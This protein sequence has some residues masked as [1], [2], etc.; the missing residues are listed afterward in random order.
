MKA[1]YEL[2]AEIARGGMGRVVEARDTRL[3]RTVA[4]KEATAGDADT[5]RRFARE[6]EIT[7][8]LEHP[9]IVPVHDAGT[10]PDGQPFYVM[11]KIAGR[12]LDALV[13]AARELDDRLPL[14]PHVVAAAHAIAHAHERGVLH[15]DIKPSNILVGDLGETIVID[16]GIAKALAGPLAD[17]QDEGLVLGTPGYIAPECARG[18][19][20]T[21]RSDV[22]ALG[23]TLYCV[24]ARRPPHDRDDGDDMVIAAGKEPV[25]PVDRVVAG[26]PAELATIVATACAFDAAERYA[27]ARA[28]ADD[29]ARFLGGR[30]VAAHHYSAVQRARRFVRRNAA[31]V[32]VAGVAVV[33][34]LAGASY[35]FAHIAAERDRA[36][37]EREIAVAEKAEA[38]RRRTEASDRADQLALGEARALAQTDPTAAVARVKPLAAKW[39]R[40]ARAIGAAAREAGVAYGFPAAPKTASLD[41]L[42]D[43]ALALG[44]DTALAVH[45]LAAR[46]TRE[47]GVFAGAEVARWV[48]ASRVALAAR[49]RVLVLDLDTAARRAIDVPNGIVATTLA[50]SPTQ[51]AWVDRD[52]AAWRLVLAD[53]APAKLGFDEPVR[54][55]AVAPRG[56]AVA[57]AGA[58]H[59]A[60]A[61]GSTVTPVATGAAT[62][63]AWTSDG[64][65][66]VALAAEHAV[67]LEVATSVVRE[68][69]VGE[70]TAIAAVGGAIYALGPAG[71]AVVAADRD[72]A[73]PRRPLAGYALGLGCARGDVAVT[74]AARGELALT[75]RDGDRTLVTPGLAVQRFASAASSHYVVAAVANHV[76]A[77]N[78]DDVLPRRVLDDRPAAIALAGADHAVVATGHDTEWL[79]LAGSAAPA[80]VDDAPAFVELA[81]SPAG[82]RAVVADVAHHARLVAPGRAAAVLGTAAIDRATFVADGRVLAGGGDGALHLFTA[83]GRDDVVARRNA[84]VVAIAASPSDVAAAFADRV[85]WRRPLAGGDADT[86]TL[87]APAAAL[88]FAADGTLVVAARDEVHLWHGGPH[89]ALR[90]KLARPIVEVVVDADRIAALADDG[91]VYALGLAGTDVRASDTGA[92]VRAVARAAGLYVATPQPTELVIVDPF[93]GAGWPLAT[94]IGGATFEQPRIADDGS[95]VVAVVPTGVLAWQLELPRDAAATAAWL[96]RLT[97]ATAPDRVDAPGLEW[98]DRSLTR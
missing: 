2:G 36:D 92:R 52:G 54:A 11:R 45:D 62:A 42:G 73:T 82:D 61:R 39:W 87:A 55:V 33:A 93:A 6:I 95:R 83:D 89:D 50:A 21:A 35:A 14:V 77:W 94:A 65:H 72:G 47:L 58:H 40:E 63:L 34:G 5:L 81:A 44:D 71:V 7:A 32:A 84:A 9:A 18:E 46:T 96:E 67:D 70:R 22:Y 91:T 43:R 88:A 85:V 10:L 16:W 12:G 69:A 60:I 27:S 28:L 86:L 25:E 97:D 37:A 78:V 1:R 31:A 26:V 80:V 48:D 53:G 38:D 19:P 4:I 66:L 20:A 29:L 51:L 30:L 23:A 24:L 49:D 74:A 76:L 8:R 17:T 59:L 98:H 75:S 56:D 15:R 13:K 3:G 41:L 79:D 90:A 68:V 57:L 64:A